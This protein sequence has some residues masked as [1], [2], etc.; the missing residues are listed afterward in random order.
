MEA[1]VFLTFPEL[2]TVYNIARVLAQYKS[3]WAA[4]KKYLFTHARA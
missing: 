1:F 4:M 3:Y 2:I